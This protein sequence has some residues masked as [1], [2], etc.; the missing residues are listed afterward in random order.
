PNEFVLGSRNLK[1]PLVVWG[2]AVKANACEL[3]DSVLV[4]WVSGPSIHSVYSPIISIS[5]VEA[6]SRSTSPSRVTDISLGFRP[7]IVR[8]GTGSRSGRSTACTSVNSRDGVS[9]Q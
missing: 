1:G 8:R 7:A 9:G 4:F 3:L 6:T 2:T 5:P